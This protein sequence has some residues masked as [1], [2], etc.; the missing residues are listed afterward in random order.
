MKTILVSG[1][2]PFNNNTI[3]PS[4]DAV[5]ALPDAIGSTRIEKLILPVY[6]LKSQTLRVRLSVTM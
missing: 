4:M 3:N 6:L 5:L 1:F 2:E